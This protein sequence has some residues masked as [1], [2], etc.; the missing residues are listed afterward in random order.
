MTNL[1]HVTQKTR[2]AITRA[3]EGLTMEQ[4]NIIPKGFNNNILWNLGHMVAVQQML[5]YGLAKMPYN[6]DDFIIQKFKKNTRPEQA[7]TIEERDTVFSFLLSTTLQQKEDYENGLI[8]EITPFNSQSLG[9]SFNTVE[10]VLIFN[11]Y[12][13]G[14]H[15]GVIQKYLQ[16]II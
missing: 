8:K 4:L 11:L 13:E 7:Y 5:I 15:T 14:L 10:E 12:H 9:T 16:I 3:V 1:F 2:E 6:V